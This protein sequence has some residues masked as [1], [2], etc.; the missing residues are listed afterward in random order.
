MHGVGRVGFSS[1]GGGGWIRTVNNQHGGSNSV[2]S[3]MAMAVVSRSDTNVFR[4]GHFGG[5]V[6]GLEVIQSHDGLLQHILR[7]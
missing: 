5:G 2:R 1:R 7:Q 3:T 6:A 4:L